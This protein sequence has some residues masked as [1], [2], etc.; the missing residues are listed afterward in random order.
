MVFYSQELSALGCNMYFAMCMLCRYWWGG[1]GYFI[2]YS[3][4]FHFGNCLHLVSHF[5]H[6]YMD[7]LL[8]KAIWEAAKGCYDYCYVEI[9]S[10]KSWLSCQNSCSL[11]PQDFFSA[12]FWRGF[13]VQSII[14]RILHPPG[15]YIYFL[16]INFIL[17][18][19]LSSFGLCVFVLNRSCLREP[20]VGVGMSLVTH[21]LR[22]CPGFRPSS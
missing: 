12:A 18:R 7:H 17:A 9:C 19:I 13:L 3:L 14:Y 16:C 10:F 5:P 20:V 22:H 21:P 8:Y 2:P 6:G 15:I 1:S 11:N 4:R